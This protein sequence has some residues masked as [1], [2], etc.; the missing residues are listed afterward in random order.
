[1]GSGGPPRPSARALMLGEVGPRVRFGE[2]EG[3]DEVAAER[4]D[5]VG[6]AQVPEQ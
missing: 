6:P 5:D 3:A 4:E 1:M 2:G